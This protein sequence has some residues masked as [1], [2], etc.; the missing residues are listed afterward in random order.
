MSTAITESSAKRKKMA[1]AAGALAGVIALSGTFA[2]FTDRVQSTATATAGT[3]DLVLDANWVD[4]D[5]YNPGD[6]AD[7]I[8][9][10]SNAGNKSVDVRERI[11]VL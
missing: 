10:I 1:L 11:V 6:K 3:V 8:Y 2:Y 9:N 7:L 4:N 5:N